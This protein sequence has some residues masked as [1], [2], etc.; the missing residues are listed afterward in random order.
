MITSLSST[1]K[2]LTGFVASRA[3]LDQFPFLEFF[4]IISKISKKVL[5]RVFVVLNFCESNI[6]ESNVL[7]VAYKSSRF[8]VELAKESQLEKGRA[9]CSHTGST[10][11]SQI[12]AQRGARTHEP[13]IKNLML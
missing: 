6:E 7:G 8:H 2:F 5:A 3:G 10:A 12:G 9:Q 4:F 1:A 13:E 11:M